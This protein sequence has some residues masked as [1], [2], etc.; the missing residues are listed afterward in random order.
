MKNFIILSLILLA[1]NLFAGQI[2]YVST[3]GS[4]DNDGRSWETAFAKIQTAIDVAADIATYDNPVEIW[5]KVGK[6]V[7][8]STIILKDNI[9]LYGGFI[10]VEGDKDE[11]TLHRQNE[12][13]LSGENTYTVL[14]N[15]YDD[16]LSYNVVLDNLV[17][18][19]GYKEDSTSY[20]SASAAVINGSVQ[21]KNCKFYKN[22]SRN[23]K[24]IEVNNAIFEN[25]SFMNNEPGA[26]ESYGA[27]FYSCTFTGNGHNVNGSALWC[28]TGLTILENCT[29]AHNKSDYSVIFLSDYAGV[30]INYCTIA[31]NIIYDGEHVLESMN[32]I[33]TGG[34]YSKCR[35]ENSI[36]M[37]NLPTKALNSGDFNIEIKYSI[38]EGGYNGIE[39]LDEDPL[40]GELGYYGGSVQTI[41]VSRKSPAIGKGNGYVYVDARGTDRVF[42]PYTLG[43]FEVP[44]DQSIS[45]C[46]I[47]SIEK[48]TVGKS[49]KIN[50][51][52]DLSGSD[53]LIFYTL[54]KN[55]CYDSS[56]YSGSEHAFDVIENEEGVNNYHV[57]I[58]FDGHIYCSSDL[59]VRILKDCKN[60]YYVSTSGSDT[61]DGLSWSSPLASIKKA[62]S[63]AEDVGTQTNP[64]EIWIEFGSYYESILSDFSN[65]HIYGGFLGNENYKEERSGEYSTIQNIKSETILFSSD[66][67]LVDNVLIDHIIFKNSNEGMVL[68]GRN[69]LQISNC[70][71]SKNKKG[72]IWMSS[73]EV[74]IENCLFEENNSFNG[75]GIYTIGGNLKVKNSTFYKNFGMYGSAISLNGNT[76]ASFENCTFV[77]NDT[78]SSGGA[79]EMSS[80]TIVLGSIGDFVNFIN[81]TI[82]NNMLYDNAKDIGCFSGLG[83]SILI[84]NTIITGG[85]NDK[86]SEHILSVD[87]SIVVGGFKGDGNINAD[88]MLGIFGYYGGIVPII[89]VLYNSPAIGRG[90]S[91]NAPNTDARGFLRGNFVTIGAFEYGC[92]SSYNTWL[93]K[94]KIESPNAHYISTPHNDGITNLEKFVFGLD[95]SRATSYGANPNFKHSVEGGVASFQFPVRKD[96]SD[97]SVK[98]MM[99]NDMSNWEEADAVSIGESGEF[100][101][102]NYSAPL[103]L[104]G[105]VFFKLKV[106]EK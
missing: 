79:S 77:E 29:I 4:D 78:N 93:N 67:A 50:V 90:T 52:T 8:G 89:P 98:L 100:N 91:I 36:V 83:T 56:M 40:L 43:A 88:P 35:I 6:Y 104:N 16:P 22:I 32:G 2:F 55:G 21:I 13:I 12:T 49:F 64:S 24:A 25:C 66:T 54:Y 17:I 60:I 72:A 27:K 105:K 103:P 11:R 82:A 63:L 102:F 1:S 3:E 58:F 85:I 71:F 81:C 62:I 5:I 31:G 51:S 94:N 46:K 106:L 84:K 53:N 80:S 18:T 48:S 76:N 10:G 38:V 33:A 59:K 86:I 95:G 45:Y 14:Y 23:G 96:A 7:N 75:A 101:L 39:V 99:S 61:N 44:S 28:N 57:E 65:V 87:H 42:Y 92:S 73:G 20:G 47:E 97:I 68:E 37:G 69:N 34:E 9:S 74:N 19:E 26:V 70:I 15:S 30:F 41:P